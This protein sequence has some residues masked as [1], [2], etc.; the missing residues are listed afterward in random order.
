[1]GCLIFT[2]INLIFFSLCVAVGSLSPA[3]PLCASGKLPGASLFGAEAPGPRPVCEEFMRF[4]PLL[5]SCS[6]PSLLITLPA[7][8]WAASNALYYLHLQPEPLTSLCQCLCFPSD[9]KP[10]ST[11]EWQQLMEASLHSPHFSVGPRLLT[12]GQ[13]LSS[14]SPCGNHIVHIEYLN[15][16]MHQFF[17]VDID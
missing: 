3:P 15:S 6:S 16:S 13:E 12:E 8:S 5:R 1:M 17:S 14:V 11:H 4:H 9:L 10:L 7:S 2:F